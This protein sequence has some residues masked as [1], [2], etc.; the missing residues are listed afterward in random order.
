M[1]TFIQSLRHR[2]FLGGFLGNV[3]VLVGGTAFSQGLLFL[4]SPLITRLYKPDDFGA[5]A[6]IKSLGLIF[7]VVASWRYE[8]S[9]VLPEKDKDAAN[10]FAGSVLIATAMSGLLL[11]VVSFFGTQVAY[12]LST[13][14]IL[15]WLWVIPLTLLLTGIYQSSNY[16][17]TR[18]KHFKRLAISRITQS[19]VIV[20]IQ[21][22]L[23]FIIGASSSGLI[24]GAVFGQIAATGALAIQIWIEDSSFL[25]KSWS[26]KSIKDGIYNNINFPLYV[27][28]YSFITN[29]EAQIILLL[30]GTFTTT[31]ILGLYSFAHIIVMMPISLI[32]SALNQVFFPKA[33]QQLESGELGKFI[34]QLLIAL[35]LVTTPLFAFF[36][37][38]TEWLFTT[39]FGRN[40]TE[41]STYGLWLGL[42]TFMM[43]YTSWIDRIYDVL[44]K[45]RILLSMEIIYDIISISCFVI[46]LIWSHNPIFAVALY[47]IINVVYNYLWL[48][49]TFELAHFSKA[50]IWKSSL[51]F[52]AI[53]IAFLVLHEIAK[54]IL[55]INFL[56]I[57]DTILVVLYYTIFAITY[58]S[59]TRSK[60]IP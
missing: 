16:W 15:P 48:I 47:S 55:T 44:G 29:L 54:H 23:P 41:A 32:A 31:K 8:L 56:L 60:L 49:I 19:I 34:N 11:F 10:L 58:Y 43:L 3:L 20:G 42:T 18:K 45:Q 2:F 35:V 59:K 28:P 38:N 53:F 4:A 37:F 36:I 24:L 57:N 5:W 1:P 9:I 13:E 51:F 14:E 12:L 50:G 25:L 22:S 30:L 27:T 52:V 40:W 17:S 7:A 26:W 21:L 39:I 6:L 46:T 33:A